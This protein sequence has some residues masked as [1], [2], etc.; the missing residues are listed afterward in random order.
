MIIND[1]VKKKSPNLTIFT[2]VNQLCVPIISINQF[3]WME[4]QRDASNNLWMSE[5]AESLK[6]ITMNEFKWREWMG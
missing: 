1:N 4:K 6:G 3:L 2:S 5:N